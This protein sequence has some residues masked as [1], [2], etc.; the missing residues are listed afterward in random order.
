[1]SIPSKNW[2]GSHIGGKSE[3]KPNG[4]FTWKFE[5]AI[6][7][8]KS[9]WQGF[10]GKN[11]VQKITSFS[12]DVEFLVEVSEGSEDQ[13]VLTIK[14]CMTCVA[15]VS[16]FGHS[17]RSHASHHNLLFLSACVSSYRNSGR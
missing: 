14:S 4:R 8:F 5:E 15:G 17:K 1:M 2:E 3:Q 11:N 10:L 9:R 16:F 12:V 13:L 6:A 7:D